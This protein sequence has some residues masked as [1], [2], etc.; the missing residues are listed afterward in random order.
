[1]IRRIFLLCIFVTVLPYA[2]GQAQEIRFSDYANYT[3]T[4]DATT[5]DLDFGTVTNQGG[6]YSIPLNM[7]NM[8]RLTGA[9]YLDVIVEV[10]GEPFLYF[11]GNPGNAGDPNRRIPFT[12]NVAY[13]NNPGDPN[14]ANVKFING[15]NNYFITN[16]PILSRGNRP[17]GPPPPPPTRNFNQSA[18]NETAGLFF[19]GNINVGDVFAGPYES[20]VT[21]TINYD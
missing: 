19:Y 1:M 9:R 20:T 18:V 3:L 6:I 13:A 8:I 12:L 14:I 15:S 7:N 4:I 11:Q 17:P 10:T 16:F 5:A 2:K 21:V